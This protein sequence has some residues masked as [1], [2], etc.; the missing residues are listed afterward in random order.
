MRACLGTVGI[1]LDGSSTAPAC[2]LPTLMSGTDTKESRTRLYT[3]M[4]VRPAPLAPHLT[5]V[6]SR[7]HR[8]R[9][10]YTG[11]N[12]SPRTRRLFPARHPGTTAG[13]QSL[14]VNDLLH[15]AL[16]GHTGTRARHHAWDSLLPDSVRFEALCD[17]RLA[18][19][20][21]RRTRRTLRVL[22]RTC[23]PPANCK[24]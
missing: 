3:S 23:E 13:S 8:A 18:T 9:R 2:T 5:F 10:D 20:D 19:C 16:L 4:R 1:K 15:V 24:R 6:D 12:S 7:V 22:R 14:R 11:A 21:M 17:S